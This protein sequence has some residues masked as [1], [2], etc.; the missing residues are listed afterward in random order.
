[1][2]EKSNQNCEPCRLSAG[3]GMVRSLCQQFKD[4]LDC[5]ELESMMDNPDSTLAEAT[6]AVK[7][8]AER[9]NGRQKQTLNYIACLMRGECES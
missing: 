7:R 3:I 6:E 8:I 1:M 2:Q 5:S 9:A 4:E